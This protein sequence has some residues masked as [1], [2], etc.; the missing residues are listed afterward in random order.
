VYRGRVKHETSLEAAGSTR[1]RVLAY[2]DRLVPGYYSACCGGTAARAVDM[3]SRNPINDTPPLDGR[4]G[5]DVCTKFKVARWT[6]KRPI[7]ELVRRITGWGRRR[8]NEELAKLK[9]LTAIEVV[10]RNEHGR[11]TRF[12]LVDGGTRIE[13]TAENLRRAA[14]ANVDGLGA[15]KHALWSS[16]VDVTIKRGTATI[17]GRGHGHGVGLC[18]YGAEELARRGRTWRQILDWYYP[19]VEVVGAYA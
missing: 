15:P 19:G 16:H 3:I 7:D 9:G 2:E 17:K 6:I 18:Q 13:M 1:G 10:E 11:P 12:A 14:N 5:E 4:D 8:R